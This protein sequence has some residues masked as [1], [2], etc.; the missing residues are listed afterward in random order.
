MGAW[1]EVDWPPNPFD[2][3]ILRH[4]RTSN[5]VLGKNTMM[6]T[7]T[8]IAE[9]TSQ[10]HSSGIRRLFQLAA[11]MRDP[12]NLSIGQPHYPV[13]EAVK[14]A[15][16]DAVDQDHN[17]YALAPGIDPLRERLQTQIDERFGH[18]DR[19]VFVCSGTSGGLTL[20]MLALVDPGDEVIHFDPYFLMYPSLIA[21]AGGTAVS[22]DLTSDF[23]LDLERL[24]DAITPRTKMIMVNS[25]TNPTGI[26]FSAAELKELGHLAAEHGIAL[27][28]DEIYSQFV[29]GDQYA[30]PAEFYPE[31]IVIDGFSKSHAMTGLRLA[32]AH[33]PQH[34]IDQM[35]KLQQFIYVCAPHPVQWGGLAALDCDTH[36]Y[37]DDY[38]RAR[39]WAVDQLSAD[40]EIVQP[41]GAFY[42]YPRL[43][44]GTGD[45]FLEAA[46][47]QNLLVIP[48]TIFSRHDTHF[49]ISYAVPQ[50]VLERGVEV[51]RRLARRRR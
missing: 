45:E 32:Y 17:D 20:A 25:P 41:D 19:K 47:S 39:D 30:S 7:R 1:H 44:W 18:A 29:Y 36:G 28:S 46:I 21:L 10:I 24:A 34:V 9:R 4:R 12:I 3:F 35:I 26:C 8:W 14:R 6:T 16:I 49:R 13:P 31:T 42:I 51:L 40:Y 5:N 38:R 2:K 37:L 23:H 48:G 27:V 33:G 43:P 15:V 50:T 11:H 22:V